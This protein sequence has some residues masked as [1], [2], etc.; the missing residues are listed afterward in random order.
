MTEP[1]LPNLKPLLYM[2]WASLIVAILITIFDMKIKNDILTAAQDFYLRMGKGVPAD[3]T[4]TANRPENG[5]GDL[6]PKPDV[7]NVARVEAA[8]L[9]PN[10]IAT[11]K[12]RARTRNVQRRAVEDS[13]AVS[14][15]ASGP[16]ND[17]DEST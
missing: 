6:L 15:G 8:I 4:G 14:E 12:T 3:E 9:G 2:L 10:G 16:A 5:G 13:G 1:E 17:T 7:A 11:S